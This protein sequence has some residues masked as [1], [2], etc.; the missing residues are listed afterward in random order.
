M[1]AVVRE[2]LPRAYPAPGARARA[3][4]GTAP[5]PLDVSPIPVIAG[6]AVACI[7]YIWGCAQVTQ[8]NYERVQLGR[9]LAQLQR[10]NQLITSDLYKSHCKQAVE[11]WARQHGM[12]QPGADC[13]YVGTAREGH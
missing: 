10:Q 4:R 9:K 2:P 6:A 5:R 7:F 12:M 13:V 3:R 11:D 1:M 8:A